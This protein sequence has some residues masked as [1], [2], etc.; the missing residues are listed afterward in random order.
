M[1]PNVQVLFLRVKDN[2]A[3]IQWIC[4]KVQESLKQDKRLFIFTP[5]AEAA[6]YVDALL[7]RIPEESFVPHKI[8]QTPTKEGIAISTMPHNFNQAHRLLN[9]CPH[10]CPIYQQFELVY[11]L[12]D[13]THP[14]KTEWA[15]KRLSAYQS[16]GALVSI[17]TKGNH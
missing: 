15:Q 17:N 3:K 10:I 2:T 9:L 12:Y 7:W 1:K 14:Q 16:A 5:N 13:E 8:V 4:S 11:E 6:S